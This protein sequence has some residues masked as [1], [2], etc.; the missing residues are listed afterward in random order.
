MINFI[1]YDIFENSKEDIEI[2]FFCKPPPG[3][4]SF[5]THVLT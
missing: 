4:A 2:F 3:A 1:E 5:Q